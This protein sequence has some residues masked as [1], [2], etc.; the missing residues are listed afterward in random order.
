MSGIDAKLRARTATMD[1]KRFTSMAYHI[2]DKLATNVGFSDDK[3]K[4]NARDASANAS[5]LFKEK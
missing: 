1:R 3:A 5:A 4:A 2:A